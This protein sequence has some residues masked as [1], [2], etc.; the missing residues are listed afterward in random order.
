MLLS[1]IL[2]DLHQ[3]VFLFDPNVYVYTKM[4]NRKY[5]MEVSALKQFKDF[6]FYNIIFFLSFYV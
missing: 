4:V 6:R 5:K 2:W 1:F 3:Q